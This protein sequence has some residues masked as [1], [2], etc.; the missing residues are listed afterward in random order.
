VRPA[1]RSAAALAAL[2]VATLPLARE[3]AAASAIEDALEGVSWGESSQALAQY[4][5]PQATVLKTPIDFG[6]SYAD[7]VLRELMVGGYKLIA[8]FQ[9]DKKSGG[10]KR[11]QLERPRHGVNPPV[12]RAVLAELKEIYGE[13]DRLCGISP[14]AANGYQAA[15]E[16]IWTKDD[17]VIRAIYR[18]TTLSASEG[19]LFGD[20]SGVGACGLTGQLLIRIEP[21]PTSGGECGRYSRFVR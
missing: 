17:I 8:F 16:R 19:C 7:V 9:M 4:F 6:D 12:G 18:D 14:G 11:V 5:G 10:L 20:S 2:L 15:A 1:A 21:A 13:P 3:A